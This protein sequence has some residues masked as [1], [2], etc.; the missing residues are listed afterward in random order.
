VKWVRTLIW[1][2]LFIFAI[3]FSIQNREEVTL[4]F[5]LY[6]FRET[7]WFERNGVPLFLVILCSIFFG[8]LVGGLSDFY[9]RLQ[10]RRM[11][12]QNQK[13]IEK[14]EKEIQSI[15]SS[16]L[17]RPDLERETAESAKE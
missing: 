4:R 17:G 5:G 11:L 10:L 9:R 3:L 6:P 16:S 7:L 14:L 13:T 1:M 8:L 15:R 2:V 12:R